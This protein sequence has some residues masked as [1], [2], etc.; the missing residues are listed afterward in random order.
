[1]K[2]EI[3][4]EQIDLIMVEE[5]YTQRDFCDED[6]VKSAC[7]ILL[8]FYGKDPDAVIDWTKK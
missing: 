3:A 6:S 7:R 8:E 2:I 4:D 5:L 1:M